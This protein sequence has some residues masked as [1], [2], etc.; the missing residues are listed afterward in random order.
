MFSLNN[1][2]GKELIIFQKSFW[3]REFILLDNSIEI[4]KLYSVKIINDLF[5]CEI[6]NQKFEFYKKN[7]FGREILIR[8]RDKQLPF[9]N[10]TSNF[11]FTSGELK[12]LRGQKVLLKI[13]TFKNNASLYESETKLLFRLRCKLAQKEKC[14]LL[15]ENKSEILKNYSWLPLFVFYLLKTSKDTGTVFH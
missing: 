11:F 3:K 1:Y 13:G 10:F 6:N 7:I 5:V 9:A 8:E 14:I 4:G 2:L 12:L 15:I